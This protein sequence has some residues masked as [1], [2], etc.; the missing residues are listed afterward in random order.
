MQP[1]C[2]LVH[3]EPCSAPGLGLSSAVGLRD[4]ESMVL[5]GKDYLARPR[6]VSWP[7]SCHMMSPYTASPRQCSGG[8]APP[9]PSFLSPFPDEYVASL[10]LP[11]FDAHLTELTDDQAKYLGLNKNGPFKPNYY[12]SVLARAGSCCLP[13]Q[14]VLLGASPCTGT[15]SAPRSC[16]PKH[17]W[18][19]CPLPSLSDTD[20][21]Y[22]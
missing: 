7:F 8:R 22:P 14:R 20:G 11:S 3:I 6:V 10:H 19:H 4:G 9:I 21:P 18:P 5:D 1:L 17:P 16:V 15:A 2:L 13:T 12:R